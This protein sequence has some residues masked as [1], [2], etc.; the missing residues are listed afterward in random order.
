[1]KDMG[2]TIDINKVFENIP[3]EQYWKFIIDYEYWNKGENVFDNDESK[4]F[5]ENA[6]KAF[7]YMLSTID[8]PLNLDL[9]IAL[10]RCAYHN[11]KRFDK[12]SFEN[13]G[14]NC[15]VEKEC[16]ETGL[17]ELLQEIDVAE[18][19]LWIYQY[20]TRFPTPILITKSNNTFA[21]EENIHRIKTRINNDGAIY[22]GS[23]LGIEFGDK[24]GLMDESQTL[25]EQYYQRIHN[26]N[27]EIDVE[28]CK[29]IKLEA[30][31]RY[32]RANHQLHQFP[33]GNGRINKLLLNKLLIMN[34]FLPSIVDDF[35]KFSAHSIA[36]LKKIVLEGQERFQQ[37]CS[38]QISNPD[39]LKYIYIKFN[40]Q[41]E[42]SFEEVFEI[43]IQGFYLKYN[44]DCEVKRY[45]DL[46]NERIFSEILPN[47]YDA[48]TILLVLKTT[49]LFLNRLNELLEKALEINNPVLIYGIIKYAKE[50]KIT[51]NKKSLTN[52]NALSV[53]PREMN[54]IEFN[55]YIQENK[56]NIDSEIVLNLLTKKPNDI[57][58]N[59]LII[60]KKHE[61]L[62]LLLNLLSTEDIEK[63]MNVITTDDNKIL[64]LNRLQYLVLNAPKIYKSIVHKL[65][66]IDKEKLLG[67]AI[68]RISFEED[69]CFKENLKE[70]ATDL[71]KEIAQTMGYHPFF[72]NITESSKNDKVIDSQIISTE[73]NVL[74]L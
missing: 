68:Y 6:S 21:S 44:E 54:Y 49:S 24:Y 13:S 16:T 27:D 38:D 15:V 72:Q 36:E 61:H 14:M 29:D 39:I 50:N 23:K 28:N 71:E 18:S 51:L 32:I 62:N 31:I 70:K 40:M 46:N 30:I 10:H 20:K 8:A 64:F 47:L 1:M 53:C 55:S 25:I 33:D 12:Y 59:V 3:A 42:N 35:G 52:I 58:Y 4:G 43:D 37:L 48:K 17:I 73:K 22:I 41:F 11:K 74:N 45:I 19:N 60:T 69:I 56:E 66:E 26:A 65:K 63:V 5:L 67:A 7:Y 34:G 2:E 57:L 9:I